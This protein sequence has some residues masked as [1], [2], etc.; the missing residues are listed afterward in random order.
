MV[1]MHNFDLFIAR[2]K[3]RFMVSRCTKFTCLKAENQSR[4][5]I[6]VIIVNQ[7]VMLLLLERNK[8]NPE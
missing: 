1:V 4:S 6:T 5:T 3:H 8:G 2:E 7:S